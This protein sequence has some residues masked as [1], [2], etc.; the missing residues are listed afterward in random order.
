MSVGE[1]EIDLDAL[2][3]KQRGDAR[4]AQRFLYRMGPRDAPHLP[5]SN[6][7]YRQLILS[8][9]GI[10][11]ITAWYARSLALFEYKVFDH[12]DLE[13]FGS[14]VMASTF[15][16]RHLLDD[17][18]LMLRFW[19]HIL[20]GLGPGLIWTTPAGPNSVAQGEKISRWP[21]PNSRAC[22]YAGFSCRGPPR[23]CL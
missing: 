15:A 4:F 5:L 9:G 13:V 6:L 8:G 23:A 1:I 17:A 20:R 12:P 10:K 2:R 11:Q 18:K 14:G 21:S 22:P 7:Q 3:S 16:P 19:P